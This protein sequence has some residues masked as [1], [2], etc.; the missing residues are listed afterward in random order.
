MAVLNVHEY[1]NRDGAPLL[2]V[3]GITAHGGRFRRLAEEAWPQ[4][5]TIAVDLRGHGRSTN[6][7]PWSIE[8]LVQDLV[9]TLD[10]LGLDALDV[11]GHSYG[12]AIGL[13]LLATHPERVA[14]FVMLD[15][16]LAQSAEFADTEAFATMEHP[17]WGSVEEATV[18]RNAG[19]GD[20]INPAVVEDVAEHL[21][22][23]ADGRYR[24]RFHRPAVVTGWGEMTHPL[25]AVLAPRSTLLVVAERAEL[26][27]DATVDHLRALLG[28]QL[29]VVR[30]DCG[31][32]LYWECFDETATAVTSFFA[33]TDPR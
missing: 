25:P 14:R 19:L 2:A 4:R 24:F 15:P 26:V 16:A 12:G 8:Q 11:V 10:A 21:Q 22:L 18:A 13:R 31:H 33:A 27:S 29:C 5:R 28:G 9:D 23:G 1:G 32:M 20:T 30:I 6:S 17:G 3:H 7:A